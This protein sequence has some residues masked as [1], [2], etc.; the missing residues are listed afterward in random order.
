M[1]TTIVAIATVVTETLIS[2]TK[3]S[4]RKYIGKTAR[5]PDIAFMEQD[6]K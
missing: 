2:P 5:L 1:K 4:K 3:N 6:K